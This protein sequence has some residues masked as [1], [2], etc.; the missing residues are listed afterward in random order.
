MTTTGKSYNYTWNTGIPVGW[1]CPVCKRV[2]SPNTVSCPFCFVP[3]SELKSE[4]DWETET[5]HEDFS[6]T[7]K[8]YS[9]LDEETIKRLEEFKK[10]LGLSSSEIITYY[11]TLDGAKG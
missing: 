9:E 10:D 4:T 6:L 8:P 3:V 5:L 7:N 2:L 1:Q 11:N